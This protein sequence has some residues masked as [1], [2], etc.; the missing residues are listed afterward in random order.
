[1]LHL[2]HSVLPLSF[3]TFACLFVLNT[4]VGCTNGGSSGSAAA[5]VPP[6]QTKS[7]TPYGNSPVT[8]LA[9]GN[10]T[11]CAIAYARL[12][13]WGQQAK[14]YMKTLGSVIEPK[15]VAISDNNGV[16]R[17][18]VMNAHS[19][20]CTDF[21]DSKPRSFDNPRQMAIT[22]EQTCVL[23]ARNA[24]ICWGETQRWDSW[25]SGQP[26]LESPTKI[27]GGNMQICAVD[28]TSTGAQ[29]KCWGWVN[30]GQ[31]TIF[32]P[33]AKL[34]NPRDVTIANGKCVA[35]DNGIICSHHIYKEESQLK[36]TG[37]Q[38]IS[39]NW[40]FRN[41]SRLCAVA[42]GQ[43]SCWTNDGPMSEAEI[44]APVFKNLSSIVY[45]QSHYCATDDDG[46]KCWG[47]DPSACIPNLP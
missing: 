31:N 34:T 42:K 7:E 43:L 6:T 46:V 41:N 36:L 19:V 11:T 45:A 39:Q 29:L 13:C 28:N 38:S 4:T 8:S 16:Q 3:L 21:S 24:V 47:D 32:G 1:M 22:A 44:K 25:T 18:C 30:P 26:T 20:L 15:Q 27:Y 14:S 2:R 40:D 35:D 37:V 9:G 12:Y 10:Y 17:A 23:T 5:Q 33:E